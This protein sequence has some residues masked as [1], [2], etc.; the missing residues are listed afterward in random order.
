MS[1]IKKLYHQFGFCINDN[2]KL[3]VSKHADKYN[4]INTS[5]NIY[6]VQTAENLRDTITNFC[7]YM[8]TCYPDIKWVRDI[9]SEHWQDWI[10]YRSPNWSDK[11][12]AEQISRISKIQLL[13][14][15]TYKLSIKYDDV[16]VPLNRTENPHKIRTIAFDKNDISIILNNLSLSRSDNALKA[17][18]IAYRCGLRSKEI[19]HLKYDNI[20]IENKV[21][22]IISGSKGGKRR[23]VPIRQKDLEYFKSLKS[24]NDDIY[25]TRGVKEE[26]LNK[27]L[28]RAL[29]IAELD[30][31]YPCTAFHAIRKTYAYE[32]YHEE[33]AKL[34]YNSLDQNDKIEKQAW[35]IVQK[36]LGHGPHYREELFNTYIRHK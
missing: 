15:K 29:Q 36:E 11:T 2:L 3:G 23:D 27:S 21:I 14:N 12:L 31:K 32:R 35:S 19:S 4:N 10:N 9:T 7:N 6:S 25:I 16:K 30:K 1:K 26:S 34:N 17:V 5:T 13:V 20:D 28:R 24:N 8:K 33:L 22:H 18:E